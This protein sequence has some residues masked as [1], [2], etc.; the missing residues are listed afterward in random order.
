M[1]ILRFSSRAE[2]SQK[3][4]EL[5]IEHKLSVGLKQIGDHWEIALPDGIH[6]H[7][8]KNVQESTKTASEINAQTAINETLRVTINSLTEDIQRLEIVKNQNIYLRESLKQTK[9]DLELKVKHSL[10]L[11]DTV[12]GL[13]SKINEL[14]DELKILKSIIIMSESELRIA[15]GNIPDLKP[16]EEP[17]LTPFQ[18]LLLDAF[19]GRYPDE[20]LVVQNKMIGGTTDS[21]LRIAVNNIP[22]AAP[23]EVRQIG[24]R[25]RLVLNEFSKRFPDEISLIKNKEIN[26]PTNAP[27]PDRT[28]GRDHSPF[29]IPRLC[30]S[31]GLANCRCGN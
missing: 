9:K 16:F 7:Q 22:D 11:E 27:K 19:S 2:A 6:F 5:A 18:R 3:A 21:D 14:L 20:P 29:H 13:E 23:F 8:N 12:A 28:L 4:R 15:L 10:I 24:S 1:S 17:D 31:C 26:I 30:D 25:E